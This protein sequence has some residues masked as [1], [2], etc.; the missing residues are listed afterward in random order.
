MTFPGPLAALTRRLPPLAVLQNQGRLMGRLN[1]APAD[2]TPDG[3]L[4]GLA[5]R[6]GHQTLARLPIWAALLMP[7]VGIE[8]LLQFAATRLSDEVHGCV[9]R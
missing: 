1:D 2:H 5:R 9:N 6:V 7:A 3:W 8:D 4:V